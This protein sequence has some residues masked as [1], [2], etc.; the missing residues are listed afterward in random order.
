M[1]TKKTLAESA[2][3][4]LVERV[5]EEQGIYSIKSGKSIVSVFPKGD[6]VIV[7]AFDGT[8]QVDV[9]VSKKDWKEFASI[10]S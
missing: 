6:E 10:L 3:S 4:L 2:K 7:T 8:R 5:T 1:T 9:K